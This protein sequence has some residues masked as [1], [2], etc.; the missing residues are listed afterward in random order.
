MMRQTLYVPV[1][2]YL[3][4]S[5]TDNFHFSAG[6]ISAANFWRKIFRQPILEYVIVHKLLAPE[7]LFIKSTKL[8]HY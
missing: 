2:L 6:Y 1:E 7:F 3:K 5:I 4:R 8:V